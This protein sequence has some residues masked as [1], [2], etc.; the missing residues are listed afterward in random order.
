MNRAVLC[1]LA[2]CLG[3]G[4]AGDHGAPA[5]PGADHAGHEGHGGHVP[6]APV[7][8]EGDMPGMPGMKASAHA[9]PAGRIEPSAAAAAQ[10]GLLVAPVRAGTGQVSRRAPAYVTFDPAASVQVTTQSGGQVVSLGV[11]APGGSVTRGQVLAR[12]Y[13]PARRAVLE[14]VR[15]ARTLDAPWRAA[16]ASRARASGI[17]EAEI[18]AVADGGAIPETFPVRSPVAG[19]VSGRP[20]SEGAWVAPGGVLALLVDAGAVLVDLVVDGAAPAP[21]TAVV[22]RDLGSAGATTAATVVGP[23][24][25]ASA[26]G[27]RVRVQALGPV[28]PGRPLVAEWTDVTA[29]GLWIPASALVDTGARRV[30]F[31]QDG[32][33]FVPRPVE[34]GVRAG[35]EVEIRAGL[36]A[37]ESVAA[38]AAFL[39]D[40]ET[41]VGSMGHAGHGAP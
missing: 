27:V 39:L 7:E 21:G 12:L 40:S 8:E 28:T 11:P 30:V 38:G 2:L 26:A 1:V 41:Q 31:V 20:V 35:D 3:C 14:D 34:P 6:A 5:T 9:S 16:A 37:G 15:V 29:P 18:R 24:P 17:E 36:S 19:V 32:A 33:G 25:E 22:L 13:D 4:H 10:L 23:L